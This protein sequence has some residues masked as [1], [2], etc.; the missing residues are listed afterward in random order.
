[1]EENV[2]APEIT[3]N[4]ESIINID[5]TERTKQTGKKV[6]YV[7]I[8]VILLII[9]STGVYMISVLISDKVNED[10]ANSQ[11]VNT[12]TP[13]QTPVTSSQNPEEWAI[14]YDPATKFGFRYPQDWTLSQQGA[15]DNTWIS[16]TSNNIAVSQSQEPVFGLLV[17]V[18]YV[19]GGSYTTQKDLQNF[20]DTQG[21]KKYYKTKEINASFDNFSG[22]PSLKYE[23]EGTE[24]PWRYHF[25]GQII[26]KNGTLIALSIVDTREDKGLNTDE[27]VRQIFSSVQ[28]AQ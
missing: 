24:D 3:P 10:I 23:Y 27:I 2:S 18:Q 21:I 6:F 28:I 17:S 5:Q 19:N 9:I 26:G 12:P 25:W 7:I 13:G 14:Y 16:I 4:T 1:M 11:I 15:G 22:F 20:V 8:S